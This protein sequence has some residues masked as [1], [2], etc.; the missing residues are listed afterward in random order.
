MLLE[1]ALIVLCNVTVYTI[2]LESESFITELPSSATDDPELLLG[3]ILSDDIELI[4][5]GH[6]TWSSVLHL[7]FSHKWPVYASSSNTHHT[8]IGTKVS[9]Q[10]KV[11]SSAPYTRGCY[12]W[13]TK[14]AKKKELA[15]MKKKSKKNKQNL[16]DVK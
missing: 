1:Q 5:R 7:G 9:L 4:L 15:K 11:V 13:E 2:P 8:L 10:P 3:L 6:Y 16:L 12:N 14:A